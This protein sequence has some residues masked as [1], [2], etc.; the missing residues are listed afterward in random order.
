MRAKVEAIASPGVEVGL[1][2]D[3][4]ADALVLADRPVLTEGPGTVDG[5]LV[6]PGGDVDV[7]VATVGGDATKVLSARAGVVGSEVLDLRFVRSRIFGHGMPDTYNVVLNERVSRPAVDSQVGVALRR[8]RAAVVDGA[9][10]GSARLSSIECTPILPA[11]TRVPALA[12]N[13]VASVAPVD[14]VTAAGS[15]GVGDISTAV[16]PER[17]EVTVVVSLGVGSN[18][19]LLDQSRVVA[20]VALSKEVEGGSDNAGDRSQSEEKGL[21]SDH[22]VGCKLVWWW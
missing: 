4:A 17:V 2:V 6:G 20:I 8:V 1:H 18:G 22:G 12:T 16:G 15:V 10:I 21:D 19:T 3:G 11:S 13:E 14:S 5:R 9:V 7:V